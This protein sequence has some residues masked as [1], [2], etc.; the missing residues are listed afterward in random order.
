M[1]EMVARAERIEAQGEFVNESGNGIWKNRF[2]RMNGRLYNVQYKNGKLAG[3]TCL[4]I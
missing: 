4:G 3:I 2:F 1:K